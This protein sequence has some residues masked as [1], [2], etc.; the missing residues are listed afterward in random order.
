[1]WQALFEK[2]EWG[3]RG[4]RCPKSAEAQPPP[5]PGPKAEEGAHSVPR[6][7]CSA[8]GD[9]LCC[10]VSPRSSPVF[11]VTFG[12]GENSSDWA[13]EAVHSHAKWSPL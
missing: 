12:A 8:L 9:I 10:L 5:R 3:P 13:L 11:V 7:L 2:R 6:H 4:W 1:M